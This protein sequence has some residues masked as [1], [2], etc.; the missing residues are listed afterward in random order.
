MRRITAAFPDRM[1]AERAIAWLRDRGVP[2]ENISALAPRLCDGTTR[3]SAVNGGEDPGTGEEA[4]SDLASETGAGL[5]AGAGGGALFG[6][7]ASMIPGIGPF[8][9]AGALAHALGATGGA[10]ASGAIVGG[11]SGAVAGALSQWGLD[12]ADAEHYGREV[13]RGCTLIAVELDGTPLSPAEV[14]NEFRRLNGTMR[15]EGTG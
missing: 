8:V 9:T 10:V 6:L 4:R 7:A 3:P 2:D 14:R 5:A 13:E 15:G 11:T 12:Q 1:D